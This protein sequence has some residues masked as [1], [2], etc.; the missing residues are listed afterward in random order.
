MPTRSHASKIKA[1][2]DLFEFSVIFRAPYSVAEQRAAVL[3]LADRLPRLSFSFRKPVLLSH[4]PNQQI[5][6][7]PNNQQPGHD[8]QHT[9]IRARFV[10]SML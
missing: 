1:G 6:D 7:K 3:V 2:E 8:V 10:R 5:R 9:L 4:R